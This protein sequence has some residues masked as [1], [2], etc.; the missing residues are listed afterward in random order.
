MK[1]EFNNISSKNLDTSNSNENENGSNLNPR[2]LKFKVGQ[3]VKSTIIGNTQGVIIKILPNAALGHSDDLYILKTED[4]SRKVVAGNLLELDEKNRETVITMKIDGIDTDVVVGTA[5][6]PED[7]KPLYKE[8]DYAI[9]SISRDRVKILRESSAKDY[10]GYTMYDAVSDSGEIRQI[11]ETMLSPYIEEQYKKSQIIEVEF[12]M[13]DSKEMEDRVNQITKRIIDFLN[14]ERAQ[15]PLKQ[16]ENAMKIHKY[17][18]QNS[19]YAEQIME[20]KTN[21]RTED[22]Y[23]NELYN[24][25][26][27]R[28]GVCTTDAIV[29]KH[30]L[31]AI[32]MDGKVAIL[33]SKDGGVH[34]ATLVSLLDGEYFY[35]DATGER[36]AFNMFSKNP[37]KFVFCLAGLGQKEY[38][39]FYIPVGILPDNLN[40]SILPMP[41]N[42][43][44]DSVPKSIISSIAN[45]IQNLTFDENGLDE[46]LASIE[47][48]INERDQAMTDL[49]MKSNLVKNAEE[50]NEER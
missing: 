31:E 47:V 29:F 1:M 27:N 24:G 14:I 20:E 25:L 32:G 46:Q 42:I 2:K 23:L 30:L 21:Y 11:S 35:F 45:G 34:A 38:N 41:T 9:D 18:V 43:S 4:G 17:I 28:K 26:V 19:T 22:T 49:F 12:S 5:L 10:I 50:R 40:R 6:N 44:N 3:Y 16:L 36:T 37:E 15:S 7:F 33:K 8:G 48:P 39:Q 13:I